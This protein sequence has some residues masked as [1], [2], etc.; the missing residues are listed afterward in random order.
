MVA[1]VSDRKQLEEQLRLSQKME[2]VGRLAGGVAHDFNNLLT[3]INGYGS[4]L[5]DSLK[6]SPYAHAY[7]EEI[8]S[9]GTR[10]A[11]LVSQ[12]LTFSRRRITQPKAIEA[13]QLV[14]DMEGMLR[15][16]I[17]EHIELTTVL[18][19]TPAGS[20][21]TSIRWRRLC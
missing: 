6:G 20:K 14:R 13:N 2:A 16:I 11:D 9:A 5:T 10:A 12:L 8:V 7:A 17:T 19:P 21:P 3:V 15:R 18:D 4:M 1:D